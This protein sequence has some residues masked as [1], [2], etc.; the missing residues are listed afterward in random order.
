MGLA[1]RQF[2]VLLVSLFV[3]NHKF[4]VSQTTLPAP[5]EPQDNKPTTTPVTIDENEEVSPTTLAPENEDVVDTIPTEPSVLA[6]TGPS[7]EDFTLS[8]DEPVA[9]EADSGAIEPEDEAT[10][11][12][13]PGEEDAGTTTATTTTTEIAVQRTEDF[14]LTSTDPKYSGTYQF[15]FQEMTGG[16]ILIHCQISVD[17]E[18]D[19]PEGE[20]P[21]VFFN[22]ASCSNIE[23][24]EDLDGFQVAILDKHEDDSTL[25][26]STAIPFDDIGDGCLV[27][28][29]PA[30][31]ADNAPLVNDDS[32]SDAQT[33]DTPSTDQS[34]GT[35]ST[36]QSNG[37][38]QDQGSTPGDDAQPSIVPRDGGSTPNEGSLDRSSA[39]RSVKKIFVP[40]LEERNDRVQW[41]PY[42]IAYFEKLIQGKFHRSKRALLPTTNRIGFVASDFR[43]LTLGGAKTITFAASPSVAFRP[44]VI[45][46]RPVSSFSGG[47]SAPLDP[48]S[49]FPNVQLPG[50]GASFFNTI[51]V[52]L[53][54]AYIIGF[55]VPFV[56]FPAIRRVSSLKIIVFMGQSKES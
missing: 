44:A 39:S 28:L 11:V 31:P 14:E 13:A 48:F 7:V 3:C 35:P 18:E 55:F 2:F 49:T 1:S 27:I 52:I 26:V 34:N 41:N 12:M 5:T 22:T 9:D 42:D 50:I 21:V 47:S 19:F 10:T 43:I 54:I 20:R 45:N 46:I 17:S 25:T 16:D 37:T 33:G 15:Q 29:V 38:P 53:V 4:A 36:D 24:I 30:P 56:G 32:P 8:D 6:T 51:S 40:S 23:A